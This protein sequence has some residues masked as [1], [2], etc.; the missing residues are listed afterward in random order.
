MRAGPPG[1]TREERATQTE[2]QVSDW[3]TKT[4]EASGEVCP[5]VEAVAREIGYV[6]PAKLRYLQRLYN[7]FI[8]NGQTDWD[9]G[10]YVLSYLRKGGEV[11]RSVPVDG[12]VGE[13][14][15]RRLAG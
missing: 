15:A 8:E 2:P 3:A 4:I 6:Q 13:R 1:R 7:R 5:E 14:V 11:S 10:A 9:F 12:A